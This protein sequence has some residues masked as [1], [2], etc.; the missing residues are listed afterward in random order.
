MTPVRGIA[1]A[2]ALGLLLLAPAAAP[3][4]W[5]NVFQVTC[6]GC[7]R[8]AV[9]AYAPPVVAAAPACPAPCPPPCPPQVAYVQRSYYTPVTTYEPV[10]QMVP[11]TS[12]Y[13]SY[14]YEPVCSYTYSSYYDPCT[15]TCQSV[16]T[17]TTSYRLRSKCN[18]VT[19]YVARISYRP[20]TTMRQ[21]CYLE[22]VPVNPCCPPAG[23][24]GPVAAIPVPGAAPPLNLQTPEPA[25]GEQR[26][27]P[28][29]GAPAP[30]LSEDR[31]YYGGAMPP[32]TGQSLRQP[33][34]VPTFAPVPPPAPAVPVKPGQIAARPNTPATVSG[35]VVANNFTP[36]GGARVV[37]V[38]AQKQEMRQAATA[39]AAGRFQVDLP[40]G[41]WY[42]YL[43]GAD[44]TPTYHSQLTV[45]A[46]ESRN[47]TVVSR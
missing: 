22:A 14:Y 20:V 7:R 45:Q 17:P 6:H 11:V 29:P 13:T 2:G 37:F 41:G 18:S 47:V 24:P 10:T 30:G 3:A 28:A 27:V 34:R 16:A 8:P 43:A 23:A 31:S 42:V 9:A 38:S 26:T 46:S 12:N 4:A 19:N 36:R 5:N 32:L 39:D 21:S 25:L 15:C 44:G 1:G 40:A 35:Q 33:P